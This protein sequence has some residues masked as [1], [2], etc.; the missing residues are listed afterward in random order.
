MVACQKPMDCYDLDAGPGQELVHALGLRSALIVPIIEDGQIFVVVIGGSAK[1]CP[2]FTGQEIELAE[3]MANAV[4]LAIK[5]ARL[6]EGTRQR[7]T[8]LESLQRMTK[9]LLQ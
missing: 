7:V 9:A 5:N 2:R 6:Y 1:E 4:G 8:E 3:G